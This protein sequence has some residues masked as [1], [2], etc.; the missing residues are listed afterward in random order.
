MDH[1]V[2]T[3]EEDSFGKSNNMNNN[4]MLDP[5]DERED[6]IN[7]N[8]FERTAIRCFRYFIIILM[9]SATIAAGVA[10]F[11]YLNGE[12]GRDFQKEVRRIVCMGVLCYVLILN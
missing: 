5:V 1:T 6:N 9:L 11:N 2:D 10:S 4:S 7:E 8:E 12:E 3:K